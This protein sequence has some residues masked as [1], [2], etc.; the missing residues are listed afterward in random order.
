MKTYSLL[1]ALLAVSI[2]TTRAADTT[3]LNKNSYWRWH[4][5]VKE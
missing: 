3:I 1:F 5:T 4:K 2:Q